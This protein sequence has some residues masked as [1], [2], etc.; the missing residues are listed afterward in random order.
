MWTRSPSLDIDSWSYT[1]SAS[2]TRA[3]LDVSQAVRQWHFVFQILQQLCFPNLC[4]EASRN[5]GATNSFLA[6][7]RNVMLGYWNF[8]VLAF[9]NVEALETK[10]GLSE[11]CNLHKISFY[12]IAETHQD[13]LGFLFASLHAMTDINSTKDQGGAGELARYYTAVSPRIWIWHVTSHGK[14]RRL[15]LFGNLSERIA[16]STKRK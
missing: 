9:S 13:H 5:T 15:V 3:V 16:R 12:H 10:Q 7:T 4:T 11:L 2:R 6:N 1:W 8:W 14:E